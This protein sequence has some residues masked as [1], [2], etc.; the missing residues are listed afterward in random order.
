MKYKN[1]H[2]KLIIL[3]GWGF[4]VH[5][6][7]NLDLNYE[8]IS[9]PIRDPLNT[10]SILEEVVSRESESGFDILAW[11]LG[12]S[13]LQMAVLNGLVLPETTRI[14][15]MC[16]PDKF[17]ARHIEHMISDLK[18]DV[19]GTLNRFYRLVFWGHQV[20]WERFREK[21]LKNCLEE[22]LTVPLRDQLEFLRDF[23]SK[24]VLLNDR[25]SLLFYSRDD[26]II[27]YDSVKEKT[28]KVRLVPNTHIP[29][30]YTEVI[31]GIRRT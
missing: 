1:T 8:Y 4:G 26:L 13:I 15:L 9:V 18:K 14:F 31:H 6:F 21:Y 19:A 10:I 2:H 24:S 17:D 27:S 25:R 11:S 12:G 16:V 23:D 5:P 28:G 22:A 30:W 29:F 20:F 3:S 7:K